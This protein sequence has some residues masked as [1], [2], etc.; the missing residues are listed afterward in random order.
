MPGVVTV[1]PLFDGPAICVATIGVAMCP[2]RLVGLL[3]VTVV[4]DG[5]PAVGRVVADRE[6]VGERP[7][8]GRDSEVAAEPVQ[9]DRVV[10][11]RMRGALTWLNVRDA[12]RAFS[13]WLT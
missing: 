1:P 13:D 5:E 6:E 12:S 2:S 11:E 8:A 3:V 4:D 7:V 10:V 9:A